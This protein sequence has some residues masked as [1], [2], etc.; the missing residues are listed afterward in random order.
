MQTIL[1]KDF[2]KEAAKILTHLKEFGVTLPKSISITPVPLSELTLLKRQGVNRLGVGLDAASPSTLKSVK[3]PY[4]WKTYWRFIEKSVSVF[5]RGNVTVHLIFG[6]GEK[7]EEF[8]K[9]MEKV[10]SVGAQVALFTF[11]PIKGTPMQSMPLPNIRN[12]R[13]VQ[14]IRLL[15]SK[16]YKLREIAQLE[17]KRIRVKQNFNLEELDSA[18]LT[19]GCPDCNRPFYDGRVK[20][21]Y[22]YPSVK[23]LERERH[24]VYSQ[25]SNLS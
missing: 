2:L 18:F 10:Y 9:T 17:G 1:K 3:K 6:L 15:L 21:I 22:N 4:D 19:S 5:G 16:G 23:L 24:A 8:I 13:I 25:A 20:L 7:I 12:Y 11:T 14:V